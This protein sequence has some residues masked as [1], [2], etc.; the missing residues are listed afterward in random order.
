[1][2]ECQFRVIKIDGVI[3]DKCRFNF[4]RIFLPGCAGYSPVKWDGDYKAEKNYYF[5]TVRRIHQVQYIVI[6]SRVTSF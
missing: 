2:G 4:S 3:N 5:D 1:M 6:L